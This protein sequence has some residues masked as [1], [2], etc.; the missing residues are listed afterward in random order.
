[1]NTD[2]T[3]AR[4]N[5]LRTLM[6]F[7]VV[8]LHTPLFVAVTEVPNEG[9]DLFK[10][11]FQNAAFRT[12]VPVLTV[13]SG[14]LLFSSS[15]VND[16]KKMYM[17]KVQSLLMPFL[18]FNLTMMAAVFAVQKYTGVAM[19]VELIPFNMNV[20]L[21]AAFG[22][23][24]NP[25]NYPLYFLRDLM[26]LMLLVPVFKW[27]LN[28]AP[29]V[30][31]ALVVVIF[32]NNLDGDFVQR[33]A[34]GVLFYAGA[35]V[36]VMKINV[37]RMDKFAW[38]CLALF[39][40]A[41]AY[42][43]QQEVTNLTYLSLIAPVLIWPAASLLDNTKVG[44]LLQSVSKFSFVVFLTHAPI[45]AITWIAYTRY[46][47][48]IPY[49]VYWVL[50]PIVTVTIVVMLYCIATRTLPYNLAERVVGC[51]KAPKRFKTEEDMYWETVDKIV[52]RD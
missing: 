35:M 10:A 8:V 31:L 46:L 47:T 21:D 38:V 48:S 24:S 29:V 5:I 41:C 28:R 9:F 3:S 22:L 19:S 36:A 30:G 23:R 17:R 4:I 7:G 27:F 49:P 39:L 45:L 33:N 37:L 20:W 26:A 44:A 18:F 6:I 40:I 50:A 52:Y 12:T 14:Y 43:I 13:I 15:L 2:L 25:I 11:F 42:V 51:Y 32:M 1:M 34:M 16:L